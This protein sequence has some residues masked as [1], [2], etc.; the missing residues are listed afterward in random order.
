MAEPEV[1]TKSAVTPGKL[2]MIAGLAVLLV[3]VLVVQLQPSGP[4]APGE[5]IS[6]RPKPRGGSNAVTTNAA[7]VTTKR[8][9]WPVLSRDEVQQHNPF[10]VSALLAP[11]TSRAD[12]DQ[13]GDARTAEAEDDEAARLREELLAELRGNGVNLIVLSEDGQVAKIGEKRIRVGDIIR[14]FRVVQIAA[15]GIELVEHKT[16]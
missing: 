10:H 5:K 7:A 14:G 16:E 3:I 15:D 1:K 6:A 12:A 4:A 13:A 8:A 9:K 2:A 11:T